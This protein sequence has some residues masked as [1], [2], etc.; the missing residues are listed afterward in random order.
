MRCCRWLCKPES[1]VLYSVE[2]SDKSIALASM[3][4]IANMHGMA[5]I[6]IVKDTVDSAEGVSNKV[7]DVVK[8]MRPVLGDFGNVMYCRGRAREWELL[9]DQDALHEAFEQGQLTL[10]VPATPAALQRLNHFLAARQP[11]RVL[12]LADEADE[13][14]TYHV[15]PESHQRSN[16]TR[17]EQQ[18]YQL[19]TTSKCLHAFVQASAAHALPCT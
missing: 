9:M 11:R 17:R 12:L 19:L 5:S 1:K 15:T 13:L 2:Q 3:C 16:T 14:W 7:K 6:V 10:V 18:M 4:S 8:A